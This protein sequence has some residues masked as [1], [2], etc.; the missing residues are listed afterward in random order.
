MSFLKPKKV[1]YHPDRMKE[2]MKEA[3]R[4]GEQND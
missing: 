4:Q 2:W 3:K 1:L